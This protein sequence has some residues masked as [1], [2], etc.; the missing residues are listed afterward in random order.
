MLTWWCCMQPGE[1]SI[2]SG[3]KG[4]EE[5]QSPPT[6][7]RETFPPGPS[8]Y[9]LGETEKENKR[10]AGREIRAQVQGR[11]PVCL[12]LLLHMA[13]VGGGE[14]WRGD[15][16]R[17]PLP[18]PRRRKQRRPPKSSTSPSAA[19]SASAHGVGHGAS[20]GPI[21]GGGWEPARPVQGLGELPSAWGYSVC[22]LGLQ[23]GA[24]GDGWKKRLRAWAPRRP[25]PHRARGS[26]S[27]ARP[28]PKRGLEEGS[29]WR[30]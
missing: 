30:G 22:N 17:A 21:R 6:S 25:L 27:E 20:A 1:P 24:G 14:G 15:K 28:G 26:P 29:P 16:L 8:N 5:S 9:P 23:R 7:T 4:K 11:K 10:E 19:S 18:A 3:Q 13:L 12:L 2:K